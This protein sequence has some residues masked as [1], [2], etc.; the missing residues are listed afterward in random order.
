MKKDIPAIQKL[1][2]Y[3]PHVR[4]LVTHHCDKERHKAFKLW[5][6][7]HNILFRHEYAERIILSF[8]H[9]LQL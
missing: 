6:N 1:A 2:F 7:L 9:Q 8:S 4:I 5:G 3:Y